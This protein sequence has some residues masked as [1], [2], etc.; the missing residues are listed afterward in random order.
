MLLDARGGHRDSSPRGPGTASH[1]QQLSEV[2]V[3]E[4]AAG[5]SANE[6]CNKPSATPPSQ[7]HTQ[8]GRQ[9]VEAGCGNCAVPMK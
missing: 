9:G 1:C 2:Q 6:T 5:A 3:G 7:F 8:R 4:T